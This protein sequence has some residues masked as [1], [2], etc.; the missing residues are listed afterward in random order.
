MDN[1]TLGTQLRKYRKLNRYTQDDVGKY[2]NVQRQTY[3]NYE[4]GIRTPDP[5]TLAA[6]ASFYQI[7]LDELLCIDTVKDASRSSIY[8][9]GVVSPSNSRLFLTGTEAKLI[10][11]YRSL[12]EKYQKAALHHMKFLKSEAENDP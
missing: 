12:P 11:D 4:R 7:T 3:S 5:K 6:L 2:L 1:S 8:H 10:I 9:E